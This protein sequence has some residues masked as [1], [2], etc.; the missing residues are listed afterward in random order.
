MAELDQVKDEIMVEII[1]AT[2]HRVRSH[3]LEKTV[4]KKLGVSRRTVDEAVKDLVEEGE[5]IFVYRDPFNYLE[6]APASPHR[7]ARPMKV[8]TDANGDTWI[9]DAD[10]D[11]A[12]AIPGQ[13]CWRCGDLPFTRDD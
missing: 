2:E 8:F 6:I 7:A 12:T 13:Q 11:P 3:E 1:N 5:L 4:G 10:V 9:C